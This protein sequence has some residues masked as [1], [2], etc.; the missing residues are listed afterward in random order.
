MAHE[1]DAEVDQVF[2]GE[3]TDLVHAGVAG[4]EEVV[5]VALHLDGDQPVL[6][7]RKLC[8]VGNVRVDEVMRSERKK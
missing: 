1:I 7:A 5:D 8:H 3:A 4:V 6:D 2:D